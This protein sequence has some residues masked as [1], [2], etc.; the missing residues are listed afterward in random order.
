VGLVVSWEDVNMLDLLAALDRLQSPRL[1]VVGDLILDRYTWG[2]AE[3]V[4]PEAPVLVL[5]AD[6]EE[7]RLGGAASVAF[8]LRALQAEV[9]LAG[10]IGDDAHGRALSRLLEETGINQEMVVTD[11]SR[12]TTTK[13]RFM[14]RAAHRHP[15]QILRVDREQRRSLD[16]GLEGQLVGAIERHLPAVQAVLVSDYAKGA[17]TVGLLENVI[18]TANRS[19][20]PVFIDPARGTDIQRYRRATLLA[21]NR[22][23]AEAATGL[24]IRSPDD[25]LSAGRNLRETLAVGAVV[26]KLDSEGMVLIESGHAEHYPTRARSV[27]DVT[28]AGDMV[29][30]MAALCRASG[31]SWDETVRLANVAAGLEVEKLGVAPVTRSEVRAELARAGPAAK[32]VDLPELIALVERHRRHGRAIVFTNGCFD[33]LHVGHARCLQEAA[34]LGHVLIVAINS[35]AG[36]RRLKGPTRP[37]IKQADRAALVASLGCV[38]HVIVFEEDTPHELLRR[39]RPDILV[40]GGTYTLDQVVGREVVESYGGKVCVIP[41]VPG[42]STTAVINALRPRLTADV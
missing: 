32:I 13:E 9:H 29:L 19:D 7:I 28:G 26:V 31:I 5:H 23:E 8:L 21:P 40:K 20:L 15:Q 18:A 24:P 3:R 4:S 14:G 6:E 10:V 36:V 2:D 16:A 38:D 39:L 37:V 25:A 1:L 22:A 34:R 12:P 33:L 17:C 11:L 41:P 42:V 30:A 35:D 27:Y